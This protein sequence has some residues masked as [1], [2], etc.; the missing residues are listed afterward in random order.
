[1]GQT[2]P[3]LSGSITKPSSL[4]GSITKPSGGHTPRNYPQLSQGR[5]R[6]VTLQE[7][8]DSHEKHSRRKP[9]EAY[10]NKDKFTFGDAFQSKYVDHVGVPQGPPGRIHH[11]LGSFNADADG[12]STR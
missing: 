3:S 5:H 11:R 7:Q 6:G 12:D 1:M 4:S 10:V 2:T 8:I 9:Q